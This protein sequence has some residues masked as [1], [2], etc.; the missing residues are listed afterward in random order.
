MKPRFPSR[1]QDPGG[2]S[3]RGFL[4]G[5]A[6]APR[7][8]AEGLTVGLQDTA[9]LSVDGPHR[10]VAVGGWTGFQPTSLHT[11]AEIQTGLHRAPRGTLSLWCEGCSAAAPFLGADGEPFLETHHTTRVADEG[12]DHPLR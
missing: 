11:R 9:G 4:A 5:L 7:A 8:R 1:V 12:P 3:R 10:F 2:L 6:L